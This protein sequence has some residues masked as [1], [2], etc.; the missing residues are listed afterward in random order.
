MRPILFLIAALIF[1]ITPV[2]AA[3]TQL[4]AYYP[5]PEGSYVTLKAGILAVGSAAGG[6]VLNVTGNSNLVGTLRISGGTTML[7]GLSVTGDATVDAKL[8]VGTLTVTGEV[9]FKDKVFA[10]SFHQTSFASNDFSGP[11]TFSNDFTVSSAFTVK[12]GAITAGNFTVTGLATVNRQLT[13]G[14]LTVTGDTS[15]QSLSLTSFTQTAA[16]ST[17]TIRGSL[18]VENLL[19]TQGTLK[20]GDLTVSRTS[21]LHTLVVDG[22]TTFKNT[23]AI[24]G[25][26]LTVGS[27]TTVGSISV[28]GSTAA[29]SITVGG[30]S[31][32]GAIRVYGE[33]DATAFIYESDQRLKDKVQ[34]ITDPL[35]KVARLNGVTFVWKKTGK[36][37]LGLVAQDVEKVLP[38]L[39]TQD[40]EGMKGVAYGNIVGVLVEAVKAQQQE[41][42]DLR[43]DLEKL[44]K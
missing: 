39:V 32:A 3:S 4:T 15:L 23:V 22:T 12:S 43:A 31:G 10:Q 17:N 14:I 26:A 5:S 21:N 16:A 13:A 29:G 8:T 30:T 27:D 33:V 24:N 44:R 9:S 19:E 34:P 35:G 2:F 40:A 41:I 11:T 1:S 42:K 28:G 6:S 20:G 38:E 36:P 37:G 25:G 7:G 18:S